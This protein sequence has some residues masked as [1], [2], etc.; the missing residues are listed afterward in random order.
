LKDEKMPEGTLDISHDREGLIMDGF[1][2]RTG[3]AEDQILVSFASLVGDAFFNEGK[4]ILVSDES[5]E[6]RAPLIAALTEKF[7]REAPAPVEGQG[8][9]SLPARALILAGHREVLDALKKLCADEGMDCAFLESSSDLGG[10]EAELRTARI[11]AMP[12]EA[13]LEAAQDERLRSREFTF[14]AIEGADKL[15]EQPTEVQ[16]KIWSC[17]LPPWERRTLLF[18]S[19]VGIRTKNL[20]IDFANNPKTVVLKKAQAALNAISTSAYRVASDQKFR[21]L[22]WLI[23][24]QA[25]NGKAAVAV[26]CNLRQTSREVEARLKLNG[27]SAEHISSA[28]PKQINSAIFSRFASLQDGS[29]K[30]EV[31]NAGAASSAT[32]DAAES[33]S[34]LVLCI[35]NDNLEAVPN[36]LALLGIHFD[37]PL[38]ADVYLER[39]RV[40]R[41]KSAAMIG[42]ACERYEVGLSAI[43]SRFGT[44]FELLDPSAEMLACPDASEGVRL[45]LERPRRDDEGWTSGP[46]GGGEARRGS[47]RDRRDRRDGYESRDSR[48]QRDAY[49]GRDSRAD[50]R[51]EAGEQRERHG[52]GD[53]RGPRDQRTEPNSDSRRPR[54][55]ANSRNSRPRDDQYRR[56]RDESRRPERQ[57]SGER[58]DASLYSMNTEERLA[59]FRNKYKDILKTPASGQAEK[60]GERGKGKN[61][62]QSAQRGAPQEPQA[63]KPVEP[64]PAPSLPPERPEPTRDG[65]APENGGIV[66]RFI[67]K[68]FSSDKESGTDS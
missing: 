62:A 7:L 47:D 5:P 29:S 57:N 4:D 60:Q 19:H 1:L 55:D 34:P 66:K 9:A 46:R 35:S 25:R 44:K 28:A 56:R 6:Y 23:Q 45:E 30:G 24:E 27:I 11:V 50:S 12:S 59:F 3:Y 41:A 39:V 13:F 38:D 16:R 40:M 53:R 26:F 22:L 2:K 14:I 54:Q 33:A 10:L 43:T 64:Q 8:P 36:E 20:A 63:A 15:S 52:R 58:G 48:P 61:P 31:G 18:A 49:E 68:L 21:V 51:Q 65:G 17:L 37:I 32:A 42:L 67:D